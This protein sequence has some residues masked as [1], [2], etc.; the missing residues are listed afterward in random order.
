MDAVASVELDL[1]YPS[2]H[3]RV[4]DRG[5]VAALA[6][7]I[8]QIGL[9]QAITVR[10]ARHA[11]N[12][13]MCDTYEVIAGLHRVKACTRLG[14]THIPAQVVEVDDLR[15]EL[16]LIDENL[17]RNDLTTAERVAATARRAKLR[18]LV[19]GPA[20]AKGA[21][22]A[23]A[24]MG[25][26]HDANAKLAVAFSEETAEATGQSVRKVQ[27]DIQRGKSLSE[28]A[29]ARVV[30]TS[31]DKGEE[32]DALAVLAR[33]A[34][35]QCEALIA[36]AAEGET[37]SAKLAVK[38]LR[39]AAREAE[40]GAKQCALPGKKYGVILADPEW[41]FA[42]WSRAT[43]MDRA[44]DNHYPTSELDEIAGRDVPSIAADDCVLFLWAT[45]P[46]LPQALA[47]MAAWGFVYRS[48]Y[49][50]VKDRAGTGY[51]NRNRHEHLLIGVRGSPPAPA[52]GVQWDSVI[53]APVGTHSA[54]P[55][56]VLAMIETYFPSLPKIEL[57]RRGP[58]R[59]GW[60][61]WGNEVAATEGRDGGE[62]AA[63]RTEAP[64]DPGALSPDAGDSPANADGEI[65]DIAPHVEGPSA[66]GVNVAAS[67]LAGGRTPDPPL[68]APDGAPSPACGVGQGGGDDELV[69]PNFLRRGPDGSAPWMHAS[70]PDVSTTDPHR[71]PAAAVESSAPAAALSQSESSAEAAE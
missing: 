68:A 51:W 32:L 69:I 16:M 29:L 41:R 3:A 23:N 48:G 28:D 1:C 46:M 38:Q 20:K 70:S 25:N 52:P 2:R 33:E 34:P 13:V 9:M 59:R 31:L 5:A 37:V 67:R 19:D 39:R 66:E 53:D 4:V 30:R 55:D 18:A 10:R 36:R 11:R 14:W 61:A 63:D 57:N 15:A 35:E 44:A 65:A 21:H 27:R 8:G 71:V 22:A 47:V 42:P 12:G 58:P 62:G 26:E 56:S 54:K 60:G 6:E 50:W 24:A 17:R 43:G 49:V 7:S 40:L 64:T 45:A